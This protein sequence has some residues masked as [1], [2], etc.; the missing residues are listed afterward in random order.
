MSHVYAVNG[1]TVHNPHPAGRLN[2]KWHASCKAILEHDKERV[3]R[4]LTA[5]GA[6]DG[7][8]KRIKRKERANRILKLAFWLQEIFMTGK[9]GGKSAQNPKIGHWRISRNLCRLS[10][11]PAHSRGNRQQESE[12]RNPKWRF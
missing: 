12:S 10:P 11:S 7:N 5:K 4:R 8:R 3:P 1:F 6:K 2:Q 9:V